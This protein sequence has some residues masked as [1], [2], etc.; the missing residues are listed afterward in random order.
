MMLRLFASGEFYWMWTLSHMFQQG[1]QRK[2][3]HQQ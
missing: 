1:S 3:D 2:T